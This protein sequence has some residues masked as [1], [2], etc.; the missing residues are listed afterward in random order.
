MSLRPTGK[1]DARLSDI[2]ALTEEVDV[3]KDEPAFVALGAA[4]GGLLGVGR[5]VRHLLAH[6]RAVV[7]LVANMT[8]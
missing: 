3:V 2:V 1:P 4:A 6:Q 5:G 7:A 8:N